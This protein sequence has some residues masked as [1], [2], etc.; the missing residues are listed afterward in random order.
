MNAINATLTR[1]ADWLLGPFAAWPPLA[2]LL[3]WSAI[4][5]VLMTIVFRYT[6]N[7]QA[8]KR[9]ADRSRA[10]ALAI[11]LFGHDPLAVFSSLGQLLHYS[12][13]RLWHS[14]PP[15]LVM[16]VP[17]VLVMSQLAL[18]YE[19][20]PLAKD[21]STI[22]K[23]ELTEKDWPKHQNVVLDPSPEFAVE[24]PA[25]RDATEHAIYW[26][27]RPK[28]AGGGTLRWRVG[29]EEIAKRV[30]V[31]AGDDRLASVSV[32][33]ASSGW[34]DRL[35]H[36]AEPALPS[37]SPV[38]GIEIEHPTRDTPLLGV[39]VP[40]WLTFVLGSIVAALVVRPLVKV[41]F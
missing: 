18:R 2:T 26:R 38:R 20:E 10:Q 17:F 21:K 9:A 31:D 33:R 13:L 41:R 22:V 25:L 12:G 15:M 4:A 28:E 27:F 5:G 1:I 14:L 30:D 37:G 34:W 24:T 23:L 11:K 16:L 39:N 35:L 7:Q 29:N 40:W 19:Y 6:S 3:F 32:R 36:P 8:V